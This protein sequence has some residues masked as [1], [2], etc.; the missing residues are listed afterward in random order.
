M[1]TDAVQ[2]DYDVSPIGFAK[3]EIPYT[4]LA[5]FPADEEL[6]RCAV[7][8]ADGEGIKVF[9][10]RVCSGDQFIASAEQKNTIIS[11]H[12]DRKSVV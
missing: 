3:G 1:S 12:Q 5:A 4:G 8:A 10:G 11:D 6:R 9:E 2:H 7:S